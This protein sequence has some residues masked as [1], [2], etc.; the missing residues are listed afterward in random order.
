ME[1]GKISG[2]INW[3]KYKIE[4]MKHFKNHQITF[5]PFADYCIDVNL[6]PGDNFCILEELKSQ[7]RPVVALSIIY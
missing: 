5:K 2:V 1:G 6:F 4:H 3:L 7:Q